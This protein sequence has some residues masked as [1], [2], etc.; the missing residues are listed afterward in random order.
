MFDFQNAN[1]L[2]EVLWR[3]KW[4]TLVIKHIERPKYPQFVETLGIDIGGH[5]G[6]GNLVARIEGG[7][8]LIHFGWTIGRL[9]RVGLAIYTKDS[10]IREGR[11]YPVVSKDLRDPAILYKLE[12]LSRNIETQEESRTLKGFLGVLLPLVKSPEL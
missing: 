4:E 7:L 12:P 6:D 3:L 11:I 9:Y 10:E 8:V 5:K 1:S 2:I